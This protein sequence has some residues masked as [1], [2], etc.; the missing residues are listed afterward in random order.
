M[1]VGVQQDD[2]DARGVVWVDGDAAHVYAV[3]PEVIQHRRAEGVRADPADHLHAGAELGGCNGLVGALAAGS[4]VEPLAD[5]RFTLGR[6]PRRDAYEVHVDAAQ[7]DDLWS[8]R[9][10]VLADLQ[11]LSLQSLGPSLGRV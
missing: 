3:P 5:D 9:L 6:Q 10:I 7:N 11:G 8:G 2:G 1:P 4:R